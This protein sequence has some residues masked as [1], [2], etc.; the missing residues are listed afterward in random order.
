M[1][2]KK[3][4]ITII[5]ILVSFICFI[6]VQKIFTVGHDR[7]FQAEEGFYHE[8]KDSLDAV[9]IG[10]SSV[11]AFW[12]PPIAWKKWGIAVRSYSIDALP[13]K[14]LP[15]L[16][17]EIDKTQPNA[18]L[19]ISLNTFKSINVN[20]VQIHRST[21]YLRFS[22][23]KMN[24]I[25][26]LA[27]DAGYKG[28]DQIQFYFPIIRFHS[29]WS[30]LNSWDFNHTDNGLKNGLVYTPYLQ[31]VSDVT[32]NYYFVTEEQ[33]LPQ[34]RAAF[35]EEFLN[36]LDESGHDVLFVS[37]P[38]AAG[39]NMRT[40]R[41]LNRMGTIIKD[42]GYP[43]LNLINAIDEMEIQTETDFYNNYHTNVHGALKFTDY[44]AQY[45]VDNY[46]FSDKR[47]QPGWE[48][49]DEAIDLYTDMIGPYTLSFE[50]E[51]APRD[52]DLAAPIL[53]KVKVK[54]QTLTISWKESPNA[55]G[56]DIYRK[57]A[58][59][60]EQNWIYLTSTESDTLQYIDSGLKSGKKYT[61]TVVPKKYAG[62]VEVYGNFD[63]TGVTGTTK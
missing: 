49:W 2:K 62:G 8:R 6:K 52:Y 47:G 14:S 59:S 58:A 11:H 4:I 12:E 41:L 35:L 38:M 16:I 3:T 18:L 7:S 5:C 48:S 27:N 43:Y 17:T 9:Y 23:N 13:S 51:H 37:S 22:L 53:N 26:S 29:R 63:F 40:Y 15:F 33:D 32:A 31:N 55:E 34:A 21:N 25:H 57:S 30:E 54:D 56:Y 42:H 60:G 1:K 24:A 28:F 10:A 19:I 50:R 44:L 39:N 45:L 61:Y 36:F 46:E 20:D